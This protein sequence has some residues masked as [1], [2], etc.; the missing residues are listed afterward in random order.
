MIYSHLITIT[1][2]TWEYIDEQMTL[3]RL[4]GLSDYWRDHPPLHILI[5]AFLGV[6]PA[7]KPKTT[8]QQESDLNQ[9]VADFAIAGLKMN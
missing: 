3:P 8:E 9:M 1:G 7:G 5:G 6:K 2:W 4:Y